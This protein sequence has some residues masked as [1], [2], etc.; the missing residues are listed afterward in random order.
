MYYDVTGVGA[1]RG[2]QQLFSAV[3]DIRK[4]H[5]HSKLSHSVTLNVIK[6]WLKSQP[7]YTRWKQPRRSASY[8][9]NKI[10]ALYPGHIFEF[11]L[12]FLDTDNL[13]DKQKK[14]ENNQEHRK[15]PVLIGV[16]IF[17]R[18]QFVVVLTGR[19]SEMYY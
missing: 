10:Q 4:R 12:M 17:S 3:K 19:K 1:L 9:R 13:L 18:Y 8:R 5:P 15:Q 14:E 7:V 6:N 16:D 2:P 11:D